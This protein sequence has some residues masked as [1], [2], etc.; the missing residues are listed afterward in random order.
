MKIRIA[1]SILSA[2]FARLEQEVKAVEEGGADLIHVDVMDGHFVPNITIGIP[3]VEALK[4]VA[5]VP[6]DVHLMISEPARYVEAFASA[7]ASMLSVHVEAA[8]QLRRTFETIKKTGISAGAVLSPE[9]DASEI[10]CVADILDFVLVMSVHPG[11]SGQE[12]IPASLSKVGQVRTL[13]DKAKNN[14]P[15][16]ID[17]GIQ[18]DNAASAVAAGAEI[19]VAASA[20]YGSKDPGAATKRLRKAALDDGSTEHRK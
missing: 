13:L 17:G 16:E 19:L 11:F 10:K 14:S 18:P 9:T 1:P 3:I 2:D 5:K 15:I 4:R 12:F 7:G 6:L 8:S 20:I